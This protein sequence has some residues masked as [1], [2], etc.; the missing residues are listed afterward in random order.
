MPNDIPNHPEPEQPTDK[1]SQPSPELPKLYQPIHG[2]PTGLE[3]KKSFR[4]KLFIIA[5]SIVAVLILLLVGIFIWYNVQLLAKG[6]DANKH[7]LVTIPSG[8][9]PTKIG[10][11]L[12]SQSVIRSSL[13]FDIY[14]RLTNKRN[15]LQAGTYRLSPSESTPT[16][17]DHL[18]K[19]DIDGFTLTFYPGATLAQHKKVLLAAGY[20]ES[21]IN[22]AF[23]ATYDSPLF[24]GKPASADLEGYIFG[25]TYKFN[26]GATVSDILK[27]TFSEFYDALTADTNII[28]GIKNQGLTLYQGITLA[29]IVQKEMASPSGLEP[30]VD[31][32]QVA[33]VFYTRLAKGI[34]L[35]SDVTFQYAATKQGVPA[36]PTLDSPYNTRLHIGLPPG[37]ISSPGITDLKAVSAPATTDYLFFLSGDD[38]ITYFAHTA[39]EHEANIKNHCVVKCS[40]L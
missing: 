29:S 16:I 40:T 34:S 36:T 22:T 23:A 14:T 8:T 20:T 17:I 28:A 31:Q 32:R 24:E 5:G 6:N 38:G 13:A 35:G 25:Q 15:V 11:L 18:V 33:Q 26:K 37:P 1:L 39:A 9:S 27:R 30:T 21:E 12:Q 19:G 3:P 7:I 10:E 4:K 2:Q